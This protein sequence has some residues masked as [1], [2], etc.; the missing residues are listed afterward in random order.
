V[1]TERPVRVGIAGLGR[2]GWHNHA[3]AITRLPGMFT[4]AAA[5]DP[6]EQRRKEAQDAFGCATYPDIEGMLADP[7]VELAVIGTPSHLH[8]SQTIQALKAGKD[9]LVDKPMAF[10][11][12]QADRMIETAEKCGRKLT[13][14]HNF[15]LTS[16]VQKVVSVINSGILGRIVLVR[17]T[18]HG[19]NRRWDW[20][21]VRKMGGGAIPNAASH[22]VHMALQF[23]GPSTPK[24]FCVADRTW[25]I[26]DAED[27]VKIILT[28][29]DAPVV[30]IEITSTCAY[31]QDYWLVMGTRGGLHG[32]TTELY[33]KVADLSALPK[34]SAET[35]PP[36]G[37]KYYSERIVW[38]PEESWKGTYDHGEANVA[39]Y[40]RLYNFLRHDGVPPATLRDARTVVAVIEECYR[41]IGF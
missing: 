23:F 12:E 22:L 27:H 2:T 28:G 5:C 32:T 35:V 20:Q 39:Y 7:N 24:V 33:W 1:N 30:D 36:E 15:T 13:V 25:G 40:T 31:P 10:T 41:Q 3:G 8:P 34:R 21:T 38:K 17:M 6:M 18:V 37:R 29:V 9:V 19:F 4:V 16:H 26:G 14:F 11:T